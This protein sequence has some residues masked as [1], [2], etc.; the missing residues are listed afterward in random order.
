MAWE[1]RRGR[2]YYYSKKRVQ[3]RVISTYLG[4]DEAAFTLA[5]FD[6]L[7]NDLRQAERAQAQA[8]R[9]EW[10]ELDREVDDFGVAVQALTAAVLLASGCHRHKRS[11]RVQR[12]QR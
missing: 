8:E 1:N 12:G 2:L 9:A 3:G 11:W 10:T 4:N 6:V 7:M 5:A